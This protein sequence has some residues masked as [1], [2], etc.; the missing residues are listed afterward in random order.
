MSW[1]QTTRI[2]KQQEREAA[3]LEADAID[4]QQNPWLYQT[5]ELPAIW[6]RGDLWEGDHERD[7]GKHA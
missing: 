6:D 3:R 1:L 7:R 4:R 5:E 2:R